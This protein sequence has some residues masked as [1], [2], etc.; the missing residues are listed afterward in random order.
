MGVVGFELRL[1]DHRLGYLP[2]STVPRATFNSEG[3]F[4][5]A[6]D[7]IWTPSAE[8]ELT[9]RLNRLYQIGYN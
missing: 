2:L 3:G 7:F 1:K 9:E 5:P 8:E 6:P 4:Q